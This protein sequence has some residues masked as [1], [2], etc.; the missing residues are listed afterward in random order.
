MKKSSYPYIKTDKTKFTNFGGIASL[1]AL[2]T[3]FANVL[4]EKLKLYTK[5]IVKNTSV[6]LEEVVP[7]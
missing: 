1:N 4:L 2:Y 7:P 5:A 3:I 6:V